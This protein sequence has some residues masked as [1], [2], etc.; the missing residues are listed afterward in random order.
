MNL[1][2]IFK[3]WPALLTILLAFCL[4]ASCSNRRTRGEKRYKE[5]S[6]QKFLGYIRKYFCSKIALLYQETYSI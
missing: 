1:T 4:D 6:S 3:H 2:V 5:L